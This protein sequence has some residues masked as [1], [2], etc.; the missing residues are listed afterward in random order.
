MLF[1]FDQTKLAIVNKNL[2]SLIEKED[3]QTEEKESQLTIGPCKHL[4]STHDAY[5]FTRVNNNHYILLVLYKKIPSLYAKINIGN[6]FDDL[7]NALHEYEIKE[8]HDANCLKDVDMRT[9]GEHEEVY[10]FVNE[11]LIESKKCDPLILPLDYNSCLSEI[12][13]I[14]QRTDQSI[15][16]KYPLPI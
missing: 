6:P 7:K 8:Y 2:S 12:K 10:L 4:S 5:L 16:N 1:H 14:K 3:K 15:D 9:G 11:L 13:I